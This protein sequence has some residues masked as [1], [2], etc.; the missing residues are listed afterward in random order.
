MTDPKE[1]TSVYMKI[2]Y[3]CPHHGIRESTVDNFIHGHICLECSYDKRGIGCRNSK[4][5][6]ENFISSING[7]TLLNKDEYIGSNV[8]NLKILCGTCG[9]NIFE[10]SFSDYYN[11]GHVKCRKCSKAY[12]SGELKIKKY[13]D[14]AGINYVHE[15]RFSDCVDQKVLPFDFYLPDYNTVIEFDGQHHF[16]P[17]VWGEE[18]YITTQIHDDIKNKYC[19]DHGINIIRIP[20]YDGHHIEGILEN[21]L[22]S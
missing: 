8:H 9:E 10:T 21:V 12:S 16:S 4:E 3:R 1:Y 2:Q 7:N 19:K 17:D 13:L 6:V 11:K 15:K 18:H 14:S 20:Y 22:A 5:Y